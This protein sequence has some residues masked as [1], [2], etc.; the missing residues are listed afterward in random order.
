MYLIVNHFPDV[1]YYAK[2]NRREHIK[3]AVSPF[4][5]VQKVFDFC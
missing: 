4:T 2:D 5:V 3:T 1:L